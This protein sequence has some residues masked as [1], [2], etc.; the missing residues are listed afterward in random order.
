MSVVTDWATIVVTAGVGVAGFWVANSIKRRRR[1]ELEVE[2]V[3]RRWDGYA[4]FFRATKPATPIRN[5][6]GGEE[7]LSEA[8]RKDLHDDLS[9][10]WFEDGGGMVLGEP[11]RSIYFIAKQNLVCPNETLTPPS[12]RR[13]V[14][15]ELAKGSNHAEVRSRL[16]IRQFSLLRMSMRADLGIMVRPYERPLDAFDRDFLRAAGVE[17]WRRP[18]WTGG[19]REWLRERLRKIAEETQ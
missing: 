6:R 16:A 19:R 12:A 7:I 11:S 9:R 10:W 8:A 18:W 4:Q 1:T 13:L 15:M 3:S 17:L 14:T 2:A 5:V